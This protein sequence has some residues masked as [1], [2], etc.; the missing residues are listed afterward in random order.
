LATK[1]KSIKTVN[2]KKPIKLKSKIKLTT[3]IK[4][5]YG[6]A[7]NE[8]SIDSKIIK[9]EAKI[10]NSIINDIRSFLHL[11]LDNYESLHGR[12]I[13]GTLFF[14][15][16]LAVA[17]FILSTY[18]FSDT[19]NFIIGGAEVFLV[20]IF[21]MEYIGRMWVAKKKMKHFFN[22][23]SLIDLA[24]IL[25]IIVHFADLTFF[26]VFRILR[27]FRMLRVLRFQR[28][29]K[30]KDTLFGKLNES[31]LIIIR[32]ILTIFTIILISSGLI[33]TVENSVNPG[34]FSNIWEAIYFV[35]VTVTTVGYG[36]ITPISGLGKFL[37]VATILSGIALIPWQLGKLIKVLMMEVT[38]TKIKCPNC[39]LEE[40]DLDALYCKNCGTKLR[41]SHVK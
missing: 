35:I 24:S 17:L 12:R 20:S 33:W 14:L 30:S 1:K 36:D 2:K 37:T 19:I 32:I 26:R 4:N 27:L 3:K 34:Q 15:N 25:P 6:K 5:S 16:F 10:E 21:L 29:F 22:P 31:E 38:K 23:Y 11:H 39:H 9:E 41:K 40:H 13:E 8:D 7:N 18:Q 28:I